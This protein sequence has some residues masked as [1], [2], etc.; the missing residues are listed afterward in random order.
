[1]SS[2]NVITTA[3]GHRAIQKPP[4]SHSATKET[5]MKV[6]KSLAEGASEF[7]RMEAELLMTVAKAADNPRVEAQ[8][9]LQI[10]KMGPPQQSDEVYLRRGRDYVHIVGNNLEHLKSNIGQ[11]IAVAEP[12]PG[13]GRRHD[14]TREHAFIRAVK[15]KNL[16][17]TGNQKLL[18]ASLGP[19]TLAFLRG[20]DMRECTARLVYLGNHRTFEWKRTAFNVLIDGKDIEGVTNPGGAHLF[21]KATLERIDFE[22]YEHSTKQFVSEGDD[23][24]EITLDMDAFVFVPQ[25][26]E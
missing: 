22:I 1:M 16:R 8:T 20:V 7:E 2:K 10:V 17:L 23:W 12:R 18:R 25:K 5:L 9:G 15:S 4:K 26:K 24:E 19:E 3:S 11:G 21:E 14:F 13:P 6:A